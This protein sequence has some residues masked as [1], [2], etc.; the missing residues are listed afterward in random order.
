[1]TW[2]HPFGW[3]HSFIVSAIGLARSEPAAGSKQPHDQ[4]QHDGTD[5]GIDDLR[6]ET[7]AEME[8][9]SWKQQTCD[10]RTGDAD[11]NIANDAEAGAT[12][13]LSSKPARDQAHE[14]NDDKAFIGYVHEI[15]PSGRARSPARSFRIY[16]E[17]RHVTT[18]I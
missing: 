10:Q 14:Q 13:D 11:E 17:T 16:P 2:G 18:P 5:R 3:P 8:S 9:K 4:Q 1:M 12:H 15:S 6:Y 7:G